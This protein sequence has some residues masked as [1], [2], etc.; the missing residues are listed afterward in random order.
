[1]GLVPFFARPLGRWLKVALPVWIGLKLWDNRA[2][3]CLYFQWITRVKLQ[4]NTSRQKNAT[5][6]QEVKCAKREV[7]QYRNKLQQHKLTTTQTTNQEPKHEKKDC[8]ER[9]TEMN[10]FWYYASF[11]FQ[12][13]KVILPV[14]VLIHSTSHQNFTESTK[15]F[16]SLCQC[17]QNVDGTSQ[18][19][20]FKT[21]HKCGSGRKEADSP[22][23]WYHSDV[24]SVVFIC[25]TQ[26][27]CASISTVT[28]SVKEE[29][30]DEGRTTETHWRNKQGEKIQQKLQTLT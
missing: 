27:T 30:T 9:C 10:L 26:S 14:T 13:G 17:L 12:K 25:L 29:R 2:Q 1:M 28:I 24:I 7:I 15:V 3:L 4:Q 11:I 20:S 18:S 23:S 16:S 6:T 19:S 5:C 8:W 21:M 22:V